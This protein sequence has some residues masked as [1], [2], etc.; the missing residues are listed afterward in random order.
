MNGP[1]LRLYLGMSATFLLLSAAAPASANPISLVTGGIA[2]SRQNAAI[3]DAG[4]L[5]GIRVRADFGED[6]ESWD[7]AHACFGCTPGTRISLSQSESLGPANDLTFVNGSVRV[8][9]VD[10]WFDS[11]SLRIR[12]GHVTI[13]DTSGNRNA[14]IDAGRFVFRSAITGTSDAGVT[15]TFR[16]RGQGRASIFFGN[17]DWFWTNYRFAD[18][19][20]AAVPEPG[21]LLLVGSGV[22]GAL[23]RR[24]KQRQ[25]AS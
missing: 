8:D 22:V 21:T 18:P 13:P 17:N 24:R 4:P 16:F 2:Y 20:A 3:F 23:A 12:A 5:S 1:R 19:A 14:A 11:V 25:L 15:R 9:D 10:Y 6:T 7:P